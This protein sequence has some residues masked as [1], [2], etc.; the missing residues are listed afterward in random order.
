M[1][2]IKL[3]AVAALCV[4]CLSGCSGTGDFRYGKWGQS[5]KKIARAE[6]TEYV[7]AAADLVEFIDDAY[8]KESEILYVFDENGL[9]EGQIKFLVGDWIL[10]DIIA[11][12]K[13]TAQTMIE[14]FGEPVEADYRVWLTDKPE[15]EEHKNDTEVYAMFYKI[16]EY[17]LE[18]NDGATLRAL[19]L[20]YKDEQI[21]YLYCAQMAK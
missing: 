5:P 2:N 10:E 9:Y 15:Y 6:P 13:E 3:A 12:Y 19:T 14:E 16:L 11:D 4:L 21:N 1:K 7:Y 18:W 8:G 17:K 20:N